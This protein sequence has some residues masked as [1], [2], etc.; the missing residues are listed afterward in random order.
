[1]VVTTLTSGSGIIGWKGRLVNLF[2][3][4]VPITP[5]HFQWTAGIRWKLVR[6]ADANE[7][8]HVIDALTSFNSPTSLDMSTCT[9]TSPG[10]V[11]PLVKEEDR[12]CLQ[13]PASCGIPTSVPRPTVCARPFVTAVKREASMQRSQKLREII[14]LIPVSITGRRGGWISLVARCQPL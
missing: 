13:R 1:M 2:S 6:V 4:P 7:K 5:F 8:R 11:V 10:A 9:L 14:R 12:L 3:F